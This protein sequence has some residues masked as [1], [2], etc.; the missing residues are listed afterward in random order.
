VC[1]RSA[2]ADR[3][4]DAPRHHARR[5]LLAGRGLGTFHHEGERH[6][7]AT[8]R[9]NSGFHV[10]TPLELADGRFL[11][12]NRGFVPYDRKNP[13]TRPEGQVARRGRDRRPVAQCRSRKAL[14][15]RAGQRSRQER[16][17]LE[18][19]RR[20]GPSAGLA[21]ETVLP[22]LRR[23]RRR[24]KPRRSAGR[25]RD[26]H[27]PAQQPSAICGDLVRAGADPG[28]RGRRLALAQPTRR[29]RPLDTGCGG[30]MFP[31][32]EP[33]DNVRQ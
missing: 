27:R 17:L 21:D 26:P 9:G 16:L 11:F 12:V 19:H 14:L 15:H 18:G 31:G 28:A 29:G 7:L 4:R 2:A 23:C 13:A 6:Y 5:R 3:H 30:R 20:H 25:R 1:G 22:F 24:A 10:I 32:H 33:T 8:W